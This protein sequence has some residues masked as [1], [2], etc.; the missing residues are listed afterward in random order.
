MPSLG[1]A[2]LTIDCIFT[3]RPLIVDAHER[4]AVFFY[5]ERLMKFQLFQNALRLS[6][7]LVMNG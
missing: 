6:T 2:P 7:H 4:F 1:L 3:S 5:N